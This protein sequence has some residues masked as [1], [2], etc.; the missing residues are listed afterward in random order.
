LVAAQPILRCP[1]ATTRS[2]SIRIRDPTETP[3]NG[4][5][6]GVAVRASKRPAA[7]RCEI[8]P[9]SDISNFESAPLVSR[10]E[11]PA[12]ALVRQPRES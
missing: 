5:A 12:A 10:V 7:G 4:L 2:R 1:S 3:A 11:Y 6:G 8:R 9:R